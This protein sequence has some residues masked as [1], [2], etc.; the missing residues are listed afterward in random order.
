MNAPLRAPPDDVPT[1]TEVVRPSELVDSLEVPQPVHAGH[2][3]IDEERLTLQI[4]WN[5]GARADA[6]LESGLRTHL[7]PMLEQ[8][9]EQLLPVLRAEL[10]SGLADAVRE[11]IAQE[12]ERSRSR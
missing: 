9:V 2:A 7:P 10:S 5:V 4:L 1:L 3:T 6:L 12:I 11:A 8:L